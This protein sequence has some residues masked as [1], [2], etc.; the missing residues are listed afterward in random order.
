MTLDAKEKPVPLDYRMCSYDGCRLSFRGPIVSLT[1]PYIAVLGGTEVFGRFV[2]QPFPELMQEWTGQSVANFGVAQAGLS[3]F[4]EE[5]WLL[6]AGSRADITVLQILGAQNMS[7][8]LYS[9]HSRRN[10]RFLSVSPALREMYPDVDFTEINFTGHLLETLADD[11]AM[12]ASLVKELKWAWVQRMRRVIKMLQG[13]VMLL[14]MS[15]R[16]PDE[17]GASR[18]ACE[19][20]FVDREMLNALSGDVAGTV[21]ILTDTNP[22]K[23]NEMLIGDGEID[24]ALC[25]PGPQDHMRAAEAIAVAVAKIKS[26]DPKD[27]QIRA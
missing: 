21:E 25:M 20:L 3:L 22:N 26:A 19:P 8:R 6:D 2:Q 14:W 23:L 4:S 12:F 7:N 16:S 13:D 17:D 24:A 10:D 27:F 18:E 5:P 15:D 1:D 9:V 11:E